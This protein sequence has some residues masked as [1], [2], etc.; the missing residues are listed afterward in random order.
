MTIGERRFAESPFCYLATR[1]RVTGRRHEVEIW[2][3]AAGSTLYLL[4]GGGRRADWV[5]NL[6]ADPAAEVRID[7]S[8][9]AVRGRVVTEPDEDR[10]ARDLVHGKYA[11][12]GTDL[13][14]WRDSA[15]PVALDIERQM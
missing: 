3:A 5:R 6:E 4:S 9:F 15:L 2:F 14:S 8:L 1:G 11:D 13:V 7:G 10:L 12:A